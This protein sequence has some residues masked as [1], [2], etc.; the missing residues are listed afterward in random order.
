MSCSV[1][2]KDSGTKRYVASKLNKTASKLR[3]IPQA[4][5]TK[6]PMMGPI[7]MPNEK[8]A[9]TRPNAGALLGGLIESE[10]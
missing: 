5:L 2:W 4:M 3:L 8:E 10:M 1:C 9:R 7:N 6:A